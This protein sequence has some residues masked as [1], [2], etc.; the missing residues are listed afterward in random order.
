MKR[1]PQGGIATISKHAPATVG[2]ILGW[3]PDSLWGGNE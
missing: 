2:I 1:V 3:S